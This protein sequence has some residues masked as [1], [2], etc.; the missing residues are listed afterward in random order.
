MSA[1]GRFLPVILVMLWFVEGGFAMYSRVLVPIDTSYQTDYWLKA[2][3][4]AAAELTQKPDGLIHVM[5]VIPRN[6]LEG[7]YPNLYTEEVVA[8]TK[9]KLEDIVEKYCP[10]DANVATSVEEGGIHHGIL[11]VARELST[12][13]IVMASHGPVIKD[14][15]V[16]SNSAH[17][18]LHAPCSVLVVRAAQ[19]E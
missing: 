1:S 11:K 19:G 6:L 2:P 17:V 14:Y 13:L 10:A 5:S 12:D 3:L 16:G 4:K 7:Y 8:E 15:L 18:A 9:R